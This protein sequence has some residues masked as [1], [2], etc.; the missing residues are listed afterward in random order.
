MD[1][2]GEVC[3]RRVE[4]AASRRPLGRRPRR[5]PPIGGLCDIAAPCAAL[6]QGVFCDYNGPLGG[7]VTVGVECYANMA[8]RGDARHEGN[9]VGN[10]KMDVGRGSASYWNEHH[11]RTQGDPFYAHFLK[12]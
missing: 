11:G 1:D 3:H 2:A 4:A 5:A 8:G 6:E 10:D 9:N 7:E 12:Q